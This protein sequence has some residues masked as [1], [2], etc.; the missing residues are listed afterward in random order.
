MN[1]L[2]IILKHV[3]SRLRASKLY[4]ICSYFESLKFFSDTHSGAIGGVILRKVAHKVAKIKIFLK[5]LN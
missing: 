3:I 4:I 1:I 2:Y 5:N